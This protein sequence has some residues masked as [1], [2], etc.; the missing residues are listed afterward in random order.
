MHCIRSFFFDA[1]LRG[2]SVEPDIDETYTTSALLSDPFLLMCFLL[3]DP[4][5][6][7][8]RLDHNYDL[9]ID[10]T[11]E[12]DL[13]QI[14][15]R[16]RRSIVRRRYVETLIVADDSMYDAFGEREIELRSY[17]LSMMAIVSAT[18]IG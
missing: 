11:G 14:N 12:L 1:C 17:L 2:I 7:E 18:F 4:G 9:R 8:K 3:T 15:R 13:V 16:Q 6:L 10:Q 5:N